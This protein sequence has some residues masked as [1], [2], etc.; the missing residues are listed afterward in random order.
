MQVRAKCS[1]CK[2][3]LHDEDRWVETENGYPICIDCVQALEDKN[4]TRFKR[5]AFKCQMC[6]AEQM[7][8]PP[9]VKICSKCISNMASFLSKEM[10]EGEIK[11]QE[12]KIL[13]IE[14]G[15]THLK[16]LLRNGKFVVRRKK[17]KPKGE[18]KS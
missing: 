18:L 9:G 7:D 16:K 5:A 10:I 6:G 3:K 1:M 8:G 2:K 13:E 15:I 17:Q 4:S 12:Q 14:T 11:D